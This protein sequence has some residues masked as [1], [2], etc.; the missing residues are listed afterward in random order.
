VVIVWRRV[1]RVIASLLGAM[2]LHPRHCEARRAPAAS[3]AEA[4][5]TAGLLDN[6]ED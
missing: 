1:I 2:G 6:L 4:I 5:L 3:R